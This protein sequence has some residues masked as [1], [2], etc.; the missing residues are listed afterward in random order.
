MASAI[1]ERCV[2]PYVH[3]ITALTVVAATVNPL[4]PVQ[5]A[6][7]IFAMIAMRMYAKSVAKLSVM[8]VSVM[9]SG[10]PVLLTGRTLSAEH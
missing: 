2:Y 7:K 9:R 10:I 3:A 6:R 1:R 5:A 4:I 8:T